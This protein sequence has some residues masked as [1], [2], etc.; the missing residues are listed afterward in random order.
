MDSPCSACSWRRCRLP[1]IT[2]SISR[3]ADSDNIACA[4]P[5]RNQGIPR[6]IARLRNTH[7]EDSYR[8]AGVTTL[9]RV[10]D[11]LINQI[12]IEIEQPRVRSIMTPG[13]G[14]AEVFAIRIPPDARSIGVRIKE[15]TRNRKFPG[16][17]VFM[18]IYKEKTDEFL[19]PRGEHI[20]SV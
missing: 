18:G 16:E 10:A 2:D 13:K 8:L 11:L 5:G 7:Y 19:I 20:I 6:V 14:K 9:V 3:Y 1:G 17:C 12:M 15:I 4:L